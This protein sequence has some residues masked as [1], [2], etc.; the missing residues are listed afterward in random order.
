MAAKRSIHQDPEYEAITPE[1]QEKRIKLLEDNV[2]KQTKKKIESIIKSNF[3]E[4]IINKDAELDA[5]DEVSS[6]FKIYPCHTMLDRLRAC[7]I[8]KYYATLGQEQVSNDC[9]SNSIHPAVKPYLG[10]TP[11]HANVNSFDCSSSSG[12][13]EN[14]SN[15]AQSL[16]DVPSTL[17]NIMLSNITEKVDDNY[18][19]PDDV[20]Y[21]GPRFKTKCKIV[22]GN[23]SKF[24][25]VWQ[26]EEND[27]ST[28][29]WMIY[30]R[31][32]KHNPDIEGFVKK[33]RFLLHPSYRP[34]DIVEISHAPF[35]LI[36][37]GWGEFPVRV[38]LH[39]HDARN[40]PVDVIHNLKLD[41]TFTGL[42]T[43]GAE[44]VVELYLFKSEESINNVKN[45]G[46]PQIQKVSSIETE[47]SSLKNA[48]S[49]LSQNHLTINGLCENSLDTSS[50]NFKL[51]VNEP[52]NILRETEGTC[53]SKVSS[54]DARN[55]APTESLTNQNNPP[56]PKIII[57]GSSV[58]N[59]VPNDVSKSSTVPNGISAAFVKCT[60]SEGRVLLVPQSSL[61]RIKSEKSAAPKLNNVVVSNNNVSQIKQQSNIPQTKPNAAV[62]SYILKVVP[63]KE[64]GQNQVLLIPM[65]EKKVQNNEINVQIKKDPVSPSESSS[66][67]HTLDLKPGKIVRK[68]CSFYKEL[69]F[70]KLENYKTFEELL[71]RVC[72]F[73]PIVKEGVDRS[74]FPHCAASL[75]EFLSWN[76]GKQRASE[77]KRA[78]AVRTAIINLLNKKTS[79]H[80]SVEH[81]WSRAAI[82]TWCRKNG[83]VPMTSEKMTLLPEP[84]WSG[85]ELCSLTNADDFIS[86]L[87]EEGDSN[88]V[89]SDDEDIDIV[90]I[91]E[92]KT[93][94]EKTNTS[95]S[96]TCHLPHLSETAIYVKKVASQV[97]IDIKPIELE[98]RIYVPAIEEMILSASK[99]LAM[100]IIGSAVNEGFERLGGKFCPEEITVSDVYSAIKKIPKFDF[101]NNSFL[102]IPKESKE[103]T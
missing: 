59:T 73:Y 27:Q 82:M 79:A 47:N 62:P 65:T 76:I 63:N 95:Q 93:T 20:T 25:P 38:Q 103:E 50:K 36:K 48:D 23:V 51:P 85:I 60:D 84:K 69:E 96:A 75:E 58:K 31:G 46:M 2:R 83:F 78:G 13:I 41:K 99:E 26:R 7:I 74:L 15:E 19:L 33:V 80:I 97:G 29:K 4:E 14:S 54:V 89:L 66:E 72:C 21:R 24:I 35:H 70:I 49:C 6:E 102:G 90:N 71:K 86:T 3:E 10:K 40:K 98:P 39:F 101:L 17:N 61:L 88:L 45:T 43:L 92:K 68:R 12:N 42:Q 37:R 56:I 55:S 57:S 64:S 87:R 18:I 11:K 5:I 94:I 100:D 16:E 53:N 9:S 77:W 67:K 8:T 22:I 1:I 28:H 52:E 30:V 32:D 81:V 91:T 34:T 44:T